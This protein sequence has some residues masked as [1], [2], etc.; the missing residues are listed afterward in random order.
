MLAKSVM[1][2]FNLVVDAVARDEEY[3]QQVGEG[4]GVCG[5]A[6]VHACVCM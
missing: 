5:G 4:E 3:L 2:D 1:P 6:R